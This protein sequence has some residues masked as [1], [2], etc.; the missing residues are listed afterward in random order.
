MAKITSR[1]NLQSTRTYTHLALETI[2]EMP[3][4][5]DVLTA[6][7]NVRSRQNFLIRIQWNGPMV[8]ISRLVQSKYHNITS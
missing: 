2:K 8:L 5:P 7:L 4:S 6:I 3:S 1:W